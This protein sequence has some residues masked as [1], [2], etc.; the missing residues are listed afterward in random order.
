MAARPKSGSAQTVPATASRS[1]LTTTATV[2]PKENEPP[3]SS[4]SRV[5]QRRRGR[6]RALGSRSSPSRPTFTAAPPPLRPV[7]WVGRDWFSGCQG[8]GKASPG[9]VLLAELR[10]RA[11]DGCHVGESTT[12]RTNST[13]DYEQLATRS[14]HDKESAVDQGKV[15]LHGLCC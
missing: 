7:P 15:R 5:A 8:R 12:S 2:Y 14:R 13:V 10:P 11:V 9:G 6:A 4:G 3:Y 1:P